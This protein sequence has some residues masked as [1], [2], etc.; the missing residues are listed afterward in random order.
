MREIRLSGWGGRGGA[1]PAIPTLSWFMAGEQVRKKQGAFHEP[2]SS[3]R[4]EAHSRLGKKSQ[5]LLAGRATRGCGRYRPAAAGGPRWPAPTSARSRGQFSASRERP[6]ASALAW[7][8]RPPAA[9]PMWYLAF[10]A[11]NDT[12]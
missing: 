11:A 9:A 8:E 7:P 6:I 1:Y 10:D 2:R 3:R 12:Y 5:S 4:K